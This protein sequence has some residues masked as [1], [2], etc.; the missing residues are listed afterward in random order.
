MGYAVTAGLPSAR[1][2]SRRD[3]LLFYFGLPVLYAAWLTGTGIRLVSYMSFWNGL[4]Y[5]SIYCLVTWWATDLGCRAAR[6]LLR[7]R[8]PPLWLVLLAGFSLTL[9]PMGFAYTITA[10]WLFRAYPDMAPFTS[11]VKF[12]WT[13]GYLLHFLRYSVPWLATWMALVY[14]YRFFFGVS[15]YGP[16][17]GTSLS[18]STI[19][20]PSIAG[21]I[22]G[23]P[24]PG[25]LA[26]SRLS[27]DA[28]IYAINAAE[29]YIRVWSDKGTDM[30]RY[31]FGDA[32]KEMQGN[33][34]MQVH[35]SW[36]IDFSQVVDCRSKG[37]SL[38]L[39]LP[40]DLRVPVSLAH[41][42][43]IR[44]VLKNAKVLH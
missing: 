7:H 41:R 16:R 4:V 1:R 17:P 32:L 30:I 25:F 19:L 43:K 42:E 24:V 22:D 44:A 33:R 31:R 6:Y 3:Y 36:W 9:V 23:P 18:D 27:N 39:S 2:P 35:R 20:A 15:W 40:G 37:R 12:S 29:H 8:H 13:P 34:G 10:D 5:M 38:E 21:A 26:E 11:N 28:E 14:G